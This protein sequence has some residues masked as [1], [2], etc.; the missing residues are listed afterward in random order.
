MKK[1]DLTLFSMPTNVIPAASVPSSSTCTKVLCITLEMYKPVTSAMPERSA[2]IGL[3][4]IFIPISGK[5]YLCIGYSHS[6]LK[7]GRK[8]GIFFRVRLC[9]ASAHFFPSIVAITSRVVF[10]SLGSMMTML[11]A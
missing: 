8:T 3:N 10:P 6:A 4:G 9:I 7:R 5:M 2:S 1:D 11:K